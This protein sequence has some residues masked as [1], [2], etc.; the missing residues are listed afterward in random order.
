MP[1]YPGWRVRIG[2]RPFRV[3]VDRSFV[4]CDDD[5]CPVDV[6]DIRT[7]IEAQ[8]IIA[9]DI[10]HDLDKLTAEPQFRDACKSAY[11]NATTKWRDGRPSRGE[12]LPDDF[13]IIPA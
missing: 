11:L 10:A 4:S 7:G 9:D 1:N 13:E 2:G 8:A 3:T 6:R 5:W 12:I